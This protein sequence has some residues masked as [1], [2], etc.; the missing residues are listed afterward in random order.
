MIAPVEIVSLCDV[1][2]QNMETAAQ[3]AVERQASKKRPRLFTDYREMLKQEPFDIVHVATPDHWHALAMI[4]AVKAGADV[5]VEKPSFVYVEEGVKMVEAARKHKRVVQAGT[6]QRS[7][8][9]FRNRS[10]A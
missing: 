5:Y 7:G 2:K 10:T 8:A 6:M 4:A 9:F 1:D 3:W